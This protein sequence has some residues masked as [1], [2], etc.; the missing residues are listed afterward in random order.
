MSCKHLEEIFLSYHPNGATPEK[1]KSVTIKQILL[2][3]FP[4]EQYAKD[5]TFQM[6][7]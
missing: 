2:V 5:L 6:N 7:R 3:R 4:M 1:E